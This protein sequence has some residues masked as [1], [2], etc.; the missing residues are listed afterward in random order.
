MRPAETLHCSDRRTLRLAIVLF[1][2]DIFRCIE[3]IKLP[4]KGTL[5]NMD[6]QGL[7]IRTHERVSDSLCR[8]LPPL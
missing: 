1:M 6:V 4:R 2:D 8:L 3:L 7:S 5:R